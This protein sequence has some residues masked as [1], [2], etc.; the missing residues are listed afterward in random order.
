MGIQDRKDRDKEEMKKLILQAAKEI[1][2]E[3][4]FDKLSIRKIAD[5]IEYRSGFSMPKRI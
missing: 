2:L 3:E 4:G 1:S 5:K